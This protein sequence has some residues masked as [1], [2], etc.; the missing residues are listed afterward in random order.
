MNIPSLSAFPNL[1]KLGEKIPDNMKTVS[2]TRR[3]VVAV[4]HAVSADRVLKALPALH[5]SLSLDTLK[6]GGESCAILQT[7]I[8]LN[9][10]FHYTPLPI[11]N[12]DFWQLDFGVL[13]R[14][15]ASETAAREPGTFIVQSFLGTRSA[16]C[17]QRA[18]A[19]EADYADFNVIMRASSTEAYSP[20]IADVHP[21]DGTPSTQMAVRNAG[22]LTL[23]APFANRSKMT[24]F[25]SARSTTYSKTSVGEKF[26]A[27]KSDFALALN[28]LP[29]EFAPVGGEIREARFGLWEKLNL[30][31]ASEM[32]CPFAILIQP[33]IKT[34]LQA[35]TLL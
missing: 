29:G 12:L 18:V 26:V 32:R 27:L 6:I 31:N 15:Q 22:E 19:S 16:W 30:L 4:S 33:E 28:P 3:H 17:V 21:T 34:V 35:P 5:P 13:V 25:L 23:Q 14:R 20:L 8:S 1:P 9:D 11:P 7:I 24:E 10:N 2:V